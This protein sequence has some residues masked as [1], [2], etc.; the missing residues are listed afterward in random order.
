M[1]ALPYALWPFRSPADLTPE[2]ASRWWEV[3]Y[4][5]GPLEGLGTEPYWQVLL[6]GPRSGKTVA[7]LAISPI[8]QTAGLGP[9]GNGFP[10]AITWL[11]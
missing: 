3:C 9:R 2:E 1:E 5:P 11:R 10:E 7:L 8:L 6:G 4:V